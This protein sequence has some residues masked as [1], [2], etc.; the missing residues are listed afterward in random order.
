MVK[1]VTIFFLSEDSDVEF[2][3]PS[4]CPD[5]SPA[6]KSR[7]HRVIVHDNRAT[8]EEL[9]SALR[10]LPQFVSSVHLSTPGT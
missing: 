10:P 6:L 3:Y 8:T 7:A 2:H 4:S 1:F 5:R 9:N